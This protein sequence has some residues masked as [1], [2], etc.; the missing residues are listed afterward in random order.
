MES[1]IN[2]AG[3]WKV[4]QLLR[5]EERKFV[6]EKGHG[7]RRD[8]AREGW[9]RWAEEVDMKTI[10]EYWGRTNAWRY[11]ITGVGMVVSGW[12]TVVAETW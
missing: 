11:A 8:T 10:V 9:K 12:A 5:E 3:K 7:T 4:R 2:G 6:L 1:G